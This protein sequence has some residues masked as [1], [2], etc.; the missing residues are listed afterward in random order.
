MADLPWNLAVIFFVLLPPIIAWLAWE[1]LKGD[2]Y[3]RIRQRER[4]RL[5]WA[6][7]VIETQ[8]FWRQP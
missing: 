5:D 1:W 6:A 7:R 3:R 8:Q 4:A 2:T